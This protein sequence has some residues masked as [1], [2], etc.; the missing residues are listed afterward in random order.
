MSP[1]KEKPMPIRTKKPSS[2]GAVTGDRKEKRAESRRA[3]RERIRKIV[4][5]HRAT[6]DELA[7]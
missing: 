7:K 2:D 6:F 4:E 5:R 1:M 3:T